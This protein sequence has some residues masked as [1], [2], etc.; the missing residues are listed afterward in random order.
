MISS[1]KYVY[2]ARE[3]ILRHRVMAVD[4][5]VFIGKFDVAGTAAET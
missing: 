1:G 4:E 2:S 3:R 5:R